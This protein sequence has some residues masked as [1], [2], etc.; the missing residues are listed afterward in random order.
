MKRCALLAVLVM[1][2]CS[3]SP[4]AV[5][6]TAPQFSSSGDKDAEFVL[7][8]G[9]LDVTYQYKNGKLKSAQAVRKGATVATIGDGVVYFN[10]KGKLVRFDHPDLQ[11]H[12]AAARF[13]QVISAA[14]LID[15]TDPAFAMAE[16][17]EDAGCGFYELKFATAL[18][19]AGGTGI[20]CFLSG[21]ACLAVPYTTV[22][23]AGSYMDLH[24]CYCRNH[25]YQPRYEEQWCN[26]GGGEFLRQPTRRLF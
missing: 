4:T 12:L 16:P 6:S 10:K 5:P 9:D 11:K 24:E 1:A 8:A 14:D 17:D 23:I 18:L 25:Y 2:A 19:A 13:G 15:C 21:V 22:G 7:H 26:G 20:G 3:E